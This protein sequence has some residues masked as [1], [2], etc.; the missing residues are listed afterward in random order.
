MKTNG[1]PSN[2]APS[3]PLSLIA[4]LLLLAS[5]CLPPVPLAAQD[6]KADEIVAEMDRRMN[7]TECRMVI[8]IED[9]KAGGKVRLLKAGVDYVKGLGTRMDFEE[10]ARDR[11]K[12]VLMS[13]SSMWMSSPAVSKPVRLS[14]KD[15][16]MGTSFTNDDVMNLD[17]SDDYASVIA[18]SDESGW[19]IVMTAKTSGLPYQKIAARIGRDFLPVSMV[20]YSRSGKESKRVSFSA[21]KDFGG[22]PRPSVMAIVDLMKPGDTSSVIFERISEEPVNRFRLTPASL[23]N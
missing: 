2:G 23:G 7:F 10:P 16:F 13:G 6:M 15:A 9:V 11:G 17:K 3:I 4:G 5:L 1:I 22:K 19:D 20:Y 14:G 12:C 21:V 8:R 18:A